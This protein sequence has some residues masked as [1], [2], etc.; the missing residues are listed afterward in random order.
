MVSTEEIGRLLDFVQAELSS[1]RDRREILLGVPTCEVF[2]KV[3][4]KRWAMKLDE[5]RTQYAIHRWYIAGVG[6][7][8]VMH[9]GEGNIGLLTLEGGVHHMSGIEG[10]DEVGREGAVL[11]LFVHRLVI[12]VLNDWEWL[13]D[14]TDDVFLRLTLIGLDTW[15]AER[16]DPLHRLA[17]TGDD[18]GT[19]RE[20]F[21]DVVSIAEEISDTLDSD[22]G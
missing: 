14:S 5:L 10:V 6:P 7:E 15:E 3:L 8:R 22:L 18:L 19:L 13:D 21:F 4:Q 16:C 12:K 11:F 2:E 1:L 17:S 9:G 20:P